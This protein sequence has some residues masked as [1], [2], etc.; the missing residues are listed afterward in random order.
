VVRLPQTELIQYFRQLPQQVE[1]VVQLRAPTA[2]LAVVQ[3]ILLS[4]QS[5]AVQPLHLVKV[6]TAAVT[7]ELLHLTSPV[8][9]VAALALWVQMHLAALKQV[10]AAMVQ[11]VRSQDLL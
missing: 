6:I 9:A 7:A 10:T 1:V 8:V 2:A 5:Q 4:Q 3:I 11:Q